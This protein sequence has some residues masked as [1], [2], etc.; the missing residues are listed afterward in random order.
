MRRL[1]VFTFAVL[2]WTAV[3]PSKLAAQDLVITNVRIIV[4]N[5]TVIDR[6]SL[7]IRDGRIS[8]VA[9]G[10]ASVSG[11]LTIDAHGMTAVSGRS[12]RG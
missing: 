6:G 5:G 3:K 4:G 2:C 7:T 9:T 10:S 1:A 12:I 11:I 8:S